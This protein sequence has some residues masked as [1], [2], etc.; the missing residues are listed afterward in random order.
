MK[1]SSIT[2]LKE[3]QPLSHDH[4]HGLSLCRKIRI[5]L[6]RSIEIERIK[7]Y[8]DW[9][10]ENSLLP[11]FY[12]EERF[13]FPILGNQNEHVTR[14]LA[15]HRKLKHYFED[16]FNL[17]RSLNK[18]EHHLENHIRFEERVLFNEVQAVAN[19]IQL[20]EI[21]ILHTPIINQWNDHFWN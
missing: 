19:V 5:G 8:S 18:I 3:L 12:T 17:F 6:N 15:E 1:K 13:I 21:G 4:H 2:R 7:R 9:F 14:A 10:Y 11:H 20:Q 16:T